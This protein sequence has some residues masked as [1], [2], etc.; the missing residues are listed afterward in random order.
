[1]SKCRE[2]GGKLEIVGTGSYGFL[3]SLGKQI[4]GHNMTTAIYRNPWH[5][6][7][8]RMSSPQFL[9]DVRPAKYRGYLIYHRIRSTVRG[10]D[11]YDVVKGGVC[12]SQL[13]GPNGARRKIDKILAD[14]NA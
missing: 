13:A 1:M 6:P 10:G 7:R 5:K 2:C 9:C 14:L 8:D 4:K 12:V 11:V 3:V